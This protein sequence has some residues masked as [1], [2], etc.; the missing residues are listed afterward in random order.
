MSKKFEPDIE[1]QLESFD[2]EEGG[3]YITREGL[4]EQLTKQ[5]Y[6]KH[7]MHEFYGSQGDRVEGMK[8]DKCGYQIWH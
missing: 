2:F 5:K 7:E 4:G 1:A 3:G 6:C 8:C